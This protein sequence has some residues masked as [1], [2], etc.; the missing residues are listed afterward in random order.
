MSIEKLTLEEYL[1]LRHAAIQIV[2]FYELGK[3]L[4]LDVIKIYQCLASHGLVRLNRL[5]DPSRCKITDKGRAWLLANW[6]AKVE[7][8]R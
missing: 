7:G 4:R 2:E 3:I 1:A 8:R 5:A 6:N